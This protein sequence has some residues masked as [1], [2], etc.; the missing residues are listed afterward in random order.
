MSSKGLD[1]VW[2]SPKTF[3]AIKALSIDI[4]K[5]YCGVKPIPHGAVVEMGVA[6]ICALHYGEKTPLKIVSFRDAVFKGRLSRKKRFRAGN[7]LA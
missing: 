4:A 2:I 7:I 3:K 6:I 5:D 1:S